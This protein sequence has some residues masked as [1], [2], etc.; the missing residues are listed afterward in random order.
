TA[1]ATW[2]RIGDLL[3]QFPPEECANYFRNSG[4]AST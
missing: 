2:R 3:D 4:Y 1:E